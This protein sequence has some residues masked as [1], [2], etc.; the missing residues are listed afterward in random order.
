MES[1][2]LGA[3]LFELFPFKRIGDRCK[4]RGFSL[5][6]LDKLLR[7]CT[8]AN[9]RLEKASS[10]LTQ[11]KKGLKQQQCYERAR[12]AQAGF[13]KATH[14][15]GQKLR[16]RG[17][18]SFRSRAYRSTFPPEVSNQLVGAYNEEMFHVAEKFVLR[19]LEVDEELFGKATQVCAALEAFRFKLSVKRQ[20][21]DDLVEC[22]RDFDIAFVA[23][24]KACLTALL[25]AK[26]R[27]DS[28]DDSTDSVLLSSMSEALHCC[29]DEGIVD[30]SMV[31][32][33]DPILLL[34]LPRL[35]LLWC[36]RRKEPCNNDLL[37]H[38]F[39]VTSEELVSLQR[40]L[41]AVP[42]VNMSDLSN[43]LV[44]GISSEEEEQS[45]FDLHKLFVGISAVAARVQDH[46]RLSHLFQSL[47]ETFKENMH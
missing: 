25:T 14:D 16:A 35:G 6:A 15:L 22:L 2:I 29:V 8:L 28:H 20:C 42:S 38:D 32:D 44:N 39:F 47:L 26:D 19:K 7:E 41:S 11:A 4:F 31:D 23:W 45:G 10:S 5:N 9:E 40:D 13:L 43:L 24:E 17:L 33:Q 1:S 46:E 37:Q 21:V 30:S 12:I 3:G 27:T 36:L 18:F 34:A